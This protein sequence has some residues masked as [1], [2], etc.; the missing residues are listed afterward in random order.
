MMWVGGA[1]PVSAEASLSDTSP[2]GLSSA[3]SYDTLPK[4]TSELRHVE[5][6]IYILCV[7]KIIQRVISPEQHLLVKVDCRNFANE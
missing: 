3:D 2:Q 7:E 4:K 5:R 6:I 1:C